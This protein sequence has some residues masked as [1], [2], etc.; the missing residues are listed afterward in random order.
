M[1]W[2]KIRTFRRKNQKRPNQKKGKNSRLSRN[3][4]AGGQMITSCTAIQKGKKFKIELVTTTTM[5]KK[6]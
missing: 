3:G 2:R 5:R 4:A 6:S 1:F